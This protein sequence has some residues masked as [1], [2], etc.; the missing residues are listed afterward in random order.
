VLADDDAPVAALLV[1]V[2]TETSVLRAYLESTS[3]WVFAKDRDH[4][5]IFVNRAFAAAQRRRP[6]DMVGRLDTEFWPAELCFGDAARGIR[7]FHADDDEAMAGRV[8]HNPEDPATLADGSLRIF[9]TI[10]QPSRSW[11]GS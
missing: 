8:I 6:E 2:R 11:T 10:K 7:S 4:R 9:D 5:L 1:A 3:D